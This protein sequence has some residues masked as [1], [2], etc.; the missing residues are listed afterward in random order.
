MLVRP[1]ARL[2]VPACFALACL[3][4]TACESP[5][6]AVLLTAESDND[7]DSLDVL[8]LE[9]DGGRPG[10]RVEWVRGRTIR[11]TAQSIQQDPLRIAV[12]LPRAGE[13][14]VH[15]TAVGQGRTLGATRCYTVNGVERDAIALVDFTLVDEDRDGFPD[16]LESTCV[17]PADGL[18]RKPCVH[19]CPDRVAQDCDDT[20]AGI[21]PG[22]PEVCEAGLDQDCDGDPND[23]CADS[24]GHDFPACG[25]S[26]A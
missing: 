3:A 8:V 5:E 2:V 14:M 20:E 19:A 11:R 9:V 1:F 17:D 7:I 25:P 18:A 26:A 22:A 6:Y 12:T 13:Y 23:P 16:E 4:L 10:D 21:F 24:D 15:V